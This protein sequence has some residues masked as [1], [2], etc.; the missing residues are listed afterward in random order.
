MFLSPSV[1]SMRSRRTMRSFRLAMICSSS[2]ECSTSFWIA[3]A[4]G[5]SCSATTAY[6]AKR[7]ACAWSFGS[8]TILPGMPPTGPAGE[9]HARGAG[10]DPLP[11]HGM[12]ADLRPGADHE[13]AEHLGASADYYTGSERRMALRAAVERRAAERHGLIDGAA[14]AP[15]RRLADHHAHAVVDEHAAA[16]LRARVDLDAGQ[17][18]ADM[19]GEAA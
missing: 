16:D 13:P 17:P 1:A 19:R 5:S 12:R 9:P 6:A 15:F 10:G 11:H 2:R 3:F 7:S 18:A 14:V 8:S 4:W